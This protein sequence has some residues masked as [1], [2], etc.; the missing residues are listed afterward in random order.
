MSHHRGEANEQR[1]GRGVEPRP[2]GEYFTFFLW[3]KEVVLVLN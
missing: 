1:S 2:G 3:K